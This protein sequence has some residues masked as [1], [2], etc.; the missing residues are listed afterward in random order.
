MKSKL[1]HDLRRY[2]QEKEHPFALEKIKEVKTP[3]SPPP[4]PP[5][6]KEPEPLS[7][8][9]KWAAEQF[10]LTTPITPII[11][12][13]VHPFLI[14]ISDALTKYIAASSLFSLEKIE[15]MGWSTLFKNP[16]FQILLLPIDHIQT[17]PILRSRLPSPTL[18]KLEA[19]L[20]PLEKIEL[21][22]HD[23][24]KKRELWEKLKQLPLS[25]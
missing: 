2:I 21:Y 10:S 15:Q 16:L 1:A 17:V 11:C 24:S 6:K 14:K 20:F 22:L 25:S 19:N 4:S 7:E 13:D 23:E 3:K 9:Q 12:L 18:Y 5:P 8:M